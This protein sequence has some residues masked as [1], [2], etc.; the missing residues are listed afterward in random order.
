MAED[1]PWAVWICPVC[2]WAVAD[3]CYL[4]IVIDPDCPGCGTRKYS[5]FRYCQDLMRR[6]QKGDV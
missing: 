4:S 6:G 1:G 3:A 2:E 5:D